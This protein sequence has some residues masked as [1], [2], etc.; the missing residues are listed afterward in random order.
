MQQTASSLQDMVVA[1][2]IIGQNKAACYEHMAQ[3]QSRKLEYVTDMIKYYLE[4]DDLNTAQHAFVSYPNFESFHKFYEMIYACCRVSIG[5]LLSFNEKI[6]KMQKLLAIMLIFTSI[7]GGAYKHV[8][9]NIIKLYILNLLQK[10]KEMKY[11]IKE[12]TDKNKRQEI[13]NDLMEVLD[14]HYKKKQAFVRVFKP[15]L[16]LRRI[17]QDQSQMIRKSEKIKL[18]LN[19]HIAKYWLKSAEIT[20]TTGTYQQSILNYILQVECNAPKELFIEKAKLNCAQEKPELATGTL[21]RSIEEHVPDVATFNEINEVVPSANKK[22]CTETKLLNTTYNDETAN[23]SMEANINNNEEAIDIN[24]ESEESLVSLAQYYDK[25]FSNMSTADRDVKGGEIL[26]NIIKCYGRS[27][28]YGCTYIYQ[29]MPRM[30]N[31]WI[32]Y[33]T[34]VFEN[35]SRD[36]KNTKEIKKQV[37][38]NMTKLIDTYLDRLPAYMFMSAFSQ[39]VS[40]ICHPLLE[41]YTQIKAI[42]IKLILHY[43]QQCMWMMLAVSKSGYAMLNKRCQEIL[44]DQRLNNPQI[45]RLINDFNLL[46]EKLI[47]LCNKPIP[48]SMKVT[49][50]NTV[51]E[52]LP[53]L[54]QGD[55]SKIIVPIQKLRKLILPNPA[56]NNSDHNPF[57]NANIYIVGIEDEIN[58]LQSMQRPKKITFRGSDGKKYIHLLKSKDDL[59]KDSRLMEFNDAVNLYFHHDDEARQNNL[60]IRTYSVVPLNEECGIVEWVDNLVPLGPVL[61]QMYKQKGKNFM[62]NNNRC[63]LCFVFIYALSYE[64]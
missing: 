45:M 42:L 61:M 6:N 19:Q 11:K 63:I 50:V 17:I 55:F 27:L 13:I 2:G 5:K 51:L 8:Y 48:D 23:I 32:E 7:K 14:L 12:I 21:K 39:I 44:H 31:C 56:I 62:T 54:L 20:R 24:K 10:T 52:T 37:L 26:L 34:R 33:G 49:S 53:R 36:D 29:S 25:L 40:R 22:L 15:V 60:Y 4:I 30:L 64:T 1:D 47:E 28:Q 35:A 46:A 9:R 58:V 59:R 41:V 38:C 57:P 16:R 43:P 3:E 18:I